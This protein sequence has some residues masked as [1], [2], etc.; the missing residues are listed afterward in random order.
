MSERLD[1]SNVHTN[2]LLLRATRILTTAMIGRHSLYLQ[3]LT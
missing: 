1:D 2:D 3:G